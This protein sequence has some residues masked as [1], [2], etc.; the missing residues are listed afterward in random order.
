[1]A[2]GL[3]VVSFDCPWGPQSII[4]NN[5]NGILVENGNVVKL[6]NTMLMLI[7]DDGQRMKMGENAI[8]S[9]NRFRIDQIAQKWLSLFCR[10]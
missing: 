9:V 5:E 7:K 8:K 2:C 6:A 1:M 4:V 3:P 10:I